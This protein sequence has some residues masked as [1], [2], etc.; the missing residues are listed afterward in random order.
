MPPP[1]HNRFSRR[2]FLVAASVTALVPCTTRPLIAS[3]LV[4][5]K[6]RRRRRETAVLGY[7]RRRNAPHPSA[8][9]QR[10][11][12]VVA[13][14]ERGV[15]ACRLSCDCLFAARSRG[16]ECDHDGHAPTEQTNE[17][18]LEA[19]AATGVPILIIAGENDRLLTA[20]VLKAVAARLPN[21]EPHAI[22][23]SAHQAHWEQPEAFNALVLAFLR[24]HP[25]RTGHATCH[26]TG[27]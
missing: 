27:K 9:V 26:L 20:D 25:W 22:P 16:D 19:I 18:T 5:D 15:R 13:G 6:N 2:C 23:N 14:A 17:V 24:R 10:Q 21:A 12:R 8:S 11:S 4:S 3:S 1:L 7:G